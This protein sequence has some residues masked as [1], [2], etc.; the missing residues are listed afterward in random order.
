[1][2]IEYLCA[3]LY[4][5]LPWHRSTLTVN[6]STWIIHSGSVRTLKIFF[7]WS[8]NM[9]L[10]VRIVLAIDLELWYLFSLR[11]V[12]AVKL[13]GPKLFM[14]RNMVTPVL[15]RIVSFW[16]ILYSDAW[17]LCFHLYYFCLYDC[18]WCR[19]GRSHYVLNYWILCKKFVE[20]HF[21]S[22]LLVHIWYYW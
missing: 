13:W 16:Y 7:L 22:T 8:I 19:L 15:K 2:D 11:F 10:N 1:M 6:C 4:L 20:R 12:S 14:I 21:V 18:I 17:S 5:V 9:H 3:A